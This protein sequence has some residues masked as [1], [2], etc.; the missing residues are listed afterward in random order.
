MIPI[1]IK[2][3]KPI[4]LDSKLK[5]YLIK[6]GGKNSLTDLL[7]E[8]FGQMGQNRGVMS[9]M[10][11]IN[12]M[13]KNPEQIKEN[14]TILLSYINQLNFIK[15]KITFG[16]EDYSC[17]IDF[18][19]LDT[20]KTNSLKTY[21]VESNQVEFEIC[22]SIYN[23]AVLYYQNGLN[24]SCSQS[25]TKE[26]RKE[27]SKNFKYAM[28]LFNWIK[29]EI[30]NIKLKETPADLHSSNLDYLISL[31]EI[32]GQTQIIEI[33]KETNP[34]DFVL[35]AKL[36]LY[37]SELY[38]RVVGVYSNIQSKRSNSEKILFFQ[39]RAIYYKAKMFLSLKDEGKRKFDE[40]G[41]EYGEVVFYI[42]FAL[43]EFKN[44]QKTIK[45]LGKMLKIED[46]EKE[47]QKVEAE[48]KEVEDLN[49]RVYKQALPKEQTK[50]ESK[51]MMTMTLPAELYIEENE[52]KAKEDERINCPDLDLMAPKEIK[53]M[54]E[55][56]KAKINEIITQNLDKCENE[57]T[58]SNFIQE[59]NLPK[60]LTKKPGEEE[61]EIEEEDPRKQLPQELWEKIEKVQQIGGGNGLMK[62]MQ[63]IMGKSNYLIGNLQN[64]LKS[65]EAEDKDDTKCRM[66]FRDK[67][68]R[69]P[70]IKLNYQLVQGAQQ[71]IQGIK[72]TQ[73]FDQ[74]AYNE[75]NNEAHLFDRL[76]LPLQ[77]LKRNIPLYIDPNTELNPEEKEVKEEIIKLYQLSDK[78]TEIIKPIFAQ[79]N[80][81]SLLIEVFMDV[82]HKKTTEQD[83]Y[84]RKKQEFLAKFTEL[85]KISE[86]VKKE[87]EVINELIQKNSEKIM[88]KPNEYEE[89][90]IMEYFRELDQLTNMFMA[91][92]E[93]IMKGDNYY[94]DLK[95][96]VDKLIKCGNDWM[97]KRSD[98][99]NALIKSL[100]GSMSSSMFGTGY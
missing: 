63:G 3:C 20:I 19:W 11:D 77:E 85:E 16:K 50:V 49:T 76:M 74:Q 55:S 84:E 31:C 44:C 48:K 94:N 51:S 47:I 67:W 36:L 14:I 97:I 46:F 88:P 26:I 41:T 65:F 90:R 2:K 80:E 56:Y 39:N 40:K 34:K 72:Q 43:N 28:Y 4:D 21:Q 6:N 86:E 5:E 37:L 93:R 100:S 89:N 62:I 66:R 59:L 22:N 13:N 27:A 92:H 75:I 95:T 45:K 15:K 79:L 1:K 61:N 23:L 18:V 81:D 10:V 82:L 29:S 24:L 35:H 83:I 12:E 99:K 71:Y 32:N 9:R 91:K 57:G 78:C 87:E 25:I 64:L 33:A 38:S 70:S 8:Y 53:N 60:K 96:K 73:G 7:K 69:E 58:I 42:N 68:I 30:Q 98:E 54:V 52:S 17:K